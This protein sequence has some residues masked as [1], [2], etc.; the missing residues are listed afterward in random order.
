MKDLVSDKVLNRSGAVGRRLAHE[1]YNNTRWIHLGIHNLKVI[2]KWWKCQGMWPCWKKQAIS[3]PW[4]SLYCPCP[5]LCSLSLASWLLWNELLCFPDM[6]LWLPTGQETAD[7]RDHGPTS[8][9][10]LS[11]F[12]CWFKYVIMEMGRWLTHTMHQGFLF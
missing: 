3:M 1:G 7:I 5:F 12:G 4:E 2:G 11:W 9:P 10:R 8:F 6:I